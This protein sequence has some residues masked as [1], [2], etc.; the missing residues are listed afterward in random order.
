MLHMKKNLSSMSV[1]ISKSI[2]TCLLLLFALPLLAQQIRT[3]EEA[4]SDPEGAIP[5]DPNVKIGQL[6]NG[7]TY[8]I[9][10]N[11]KPEDKAE[12]RLVIKAGSI[13]EDEDQQGLA[14]FVEHMAFNGTKNF[15]KNELVSYLQSIGVKFGADLNAYTSFDE[16]VYILPVPTEDEE[17]LNKAFQILEDWAGN[18]TFDPEE[19]DKERGV[20]IEEWRRGLGASE[21]LRQQ[22]FPKL[23]K[24]SRYVDRLPIG[25]KE[26][27]ENFDYETLKRFYQD[28][29]R[30]NLMAVVAVGDFDPAQIEQKIKQHFGR[31]ENPETLKERKTYDIPG[32][33]ETLVSIA[34][35]KEESFTQVQVIYKHGPEPVE[36]V[37]QY[38]NTV[39]HQLYNGMINQRLSELTQQAEPPFIFGSTSYGPF[40]GDI[41]AY[42]AFAV[43]GD[44]GVD[45]ALKTLLE[46]SKR[47]LTHGF[48]Q[49]ELERY[50]K[51]MLASM[52]KAYNE[53]DKTESGR[54]VGEYIRNFLDD[55]PIPGISFEYEF[56]Q[57]YVPEV[58]LDEV[59]ALAQN[60]ITE[61]NRVVII[62]GPEKEGVEM[63]TEE[64]VRQVLNEVGQMD[65]S[66]YED[67][68]TATELMEQTPAPGSV[69]SQNEREHGITELVL[70][71]GVTVVLKP[72]DFKNDE[73]LMSAFSPGGASLYPDEAYYSATNADGIVVESGVKDLSSTDIDKLLTG[74]NV[75]VA[76]YISSLTEG[77]SG[78]A[79]P[80]DVEAMLQLLH[81]YFTAPRQDMQAFQ[82]YVNKNKMIYS[83]LLSNPQYFFLD[84]VSEIMSQD[85]PRGGGFPSAED[86]DSIDYE[87]A[88]EIYSE[89][90]TDASDFTFVFVGNFDVEEMKQMLLPY[91]G[92]L[93]DTDRDENWK[94]VGVRYPE[95]K[96]D[97][98][99]YKGTDP[100][101]QVTINFTGYFDYDKKL[102]YHMSSMTDI[103]KNRLIDVVREEESGVYSISAGLS[104]Q[105][106]PIG[107]YRLNIQFPCAP[108]NA[109]KLSQLAIA[110]FEKLRSEGPA[111]KDLEKIKEAQRLEMK[112]NLKQNRYWLNKILN[113]WQYNEDLTDM[114]DYEERIAALTAKDIKKVAKKYFDI[115]EYVKITLLPEGFEQ[116]QGR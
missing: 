57:K 16:T 115:D 91:L 46:E 62:T 102:V 47:V 12:L 26:V 32:H 107:S 43:A 71:N 24:G 83:N 34:T 60:W 29:Y 84:K 100:K 90:F 33:Q 22:Y 89:R 31:L 64:E 104:A 63:P 93:P 72:T 114:L 21:R 36:T 94:D 4:L 30:P 92:S 56:M 42:T 59:N 7:L 95:G 37:E 15:A 108:E 41:N 58:S 40:L 3:T 85:H 87:Q 5:T 116:G 17:T 19:I 75:R 79:T 65:I 113:A 98:K 10:Q 18:L 112:E 51:Q 6:D 81:L 38:R 109:D 49:S 106:R 8:Y 25:K 111:E 76:P 66:P 9:R 82:S 45:K 110:E 101:S 14:H 69:A 23:L 86:W 105:R 20:V 48:T 97:E 44:G 54:Y 77:F 74:K 13:L 103:L 67:A 53:R 80:K 78:S 73:I 1:K 11:P 39:V 68:L 2:S 28:W 61:T 27:L 88:F 70:S 50:K 55:E 52:E 99:V 96:I 35:D